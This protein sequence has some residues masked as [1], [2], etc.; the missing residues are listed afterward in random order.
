MCTEAATAGHLYTRVKG[1]SLNGP[2]PSAPPPGRKAEADSKNDDDDDAKADA[3]MQKMQKQA[4]EFLG[5]QK[6]K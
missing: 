2:D 4:Q 6:Q 1:A 5:R 3:L